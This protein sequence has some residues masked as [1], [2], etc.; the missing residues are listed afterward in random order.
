MDTEILNKVI[1]DAMASAI[2]PL[3]KELDD[4]KEKTI[5]ATTTA[6]PQE[7]EPDWEMFDRAARELNLI[8]KP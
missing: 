4:L 1:T 8:V 6:Q 3:R 5:T 2:R 7:D